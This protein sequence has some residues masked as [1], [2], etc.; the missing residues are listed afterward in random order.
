VN[1][2]S[3]PKLPKLKDVLTEEFKQQQE[4]RQQKD[5]EYLKRG[6]LLKDELRK[7]RELKE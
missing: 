7:Q 3:L 2:H 1:D 6:V 5:I 4:Q